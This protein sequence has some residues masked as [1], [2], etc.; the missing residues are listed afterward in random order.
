[1]VFRHH[2]GSESFSRATGGKMGI[3]WCVAGGVPPKQ[4]ARRL[5]LA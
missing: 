4:V 1:L 2:A 5:D 3:G